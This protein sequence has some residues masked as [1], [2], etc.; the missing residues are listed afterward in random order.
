V[1]LIRHRFGLASAAL[2]LALAVL[3]AQAADS[4]KKKTVAAPDVNTDPTVGVFGAHKIQSEPQGAK[5]HPSAPV[6]AAPVTKVESEAPT[7][8][9]PPS[10][11]YSSTPSHAQPVPLSS[12]PR[13][14][15]TAGTTEP[16]AIP[17]EAPPAP[18]SGF[19]ATHPYASGLVAGAV[20]TDIGGWI[21][22][23]E[24]IGDQDAVL[25]GYLGRL[26]F[27][28]LIFVL[29]V[30][31]ALA[32]RNRSTYDDFSPTDAPRR[33]PSFGGDNAK[34][35]HSSDLRAEP[36]LP[37]SGSKGSHRF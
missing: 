25:I 23:G 35:D 32:R 26:G 37:R 29:A 7:V 19:L 3:P 27:I 24:M 9:M 28:V 21:Y 20:G 13:P 5:S 12:S 10:S 34:A 18:P 4:V 16:S 36:L 17:G 8:T 6:A 11:P 14:Q 15:G 30:R 33:E 1:H 2:L 22:G 31:V